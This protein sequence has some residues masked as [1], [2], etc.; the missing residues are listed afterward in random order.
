MKDVTTSLIVFQVS[1][2][3]LHRSARVPPPFL[4]YNGNSRILFQLCE[5]KT[6]S[7]ATGENPSTVLASVFWNSGL[8][9]SLF[10]SYLG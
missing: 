3:I 5:P 10:A 9:P 1:E 2:I 8:T 6:S 4:W 7:G